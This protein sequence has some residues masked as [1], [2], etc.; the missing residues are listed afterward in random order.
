MK[1]LFATGFGNAR[2]PWFDMHPAGVP[3]GSAQLGRPLTASEID[4]YTAKIVQGRQKLAPIPALIAARIDADP[5]LQKTINDP[6][7]QKNFWDFMDLANKDQY[8]VD[9]TWDMLQNPTSADYD[10]PDEN[11]GRTDEWALVIDDLMYVPQNYGKGFVGPKPA[12]GPIPVIPGVTPGANIRT[13]PP[14]LPGA[15]PMVLGVPQ[16]TFLIG[17]GVLR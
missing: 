7:V 13:S 3:L 10:I 11:L 16:N 15:Q 1:T 17:A 5:M 14:A 8:Y 4:Q 2:N 12:A 9:Q 6:V